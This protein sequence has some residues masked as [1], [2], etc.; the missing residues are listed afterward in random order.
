[1]F[2]TGFSNLENDQSLIKGCAENNRIAQNHLYTTYAAQMMGICLRYARTREDAQDILQEGFVQVFK[3]IKQYKFKGPLEAWL[4]KIF[5][6][7]ALQKLREKENNYLFVPIDNDTE[8][9]KNSYHISEEVDLKILIKCIQ[10]LPLISRLVFNLY[11]FEGLKHREIAH[12]LKITE[13]TSK[14][15]L[16]DARNNLKKQLQNLDYFS[17]KTAANE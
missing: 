13:G 5:I 15:N 9:Y 7:C 6:N 17:L 1:M 11:A 3:C 4:K 16:F 10:N 14:S 12:I 8:I 2:S